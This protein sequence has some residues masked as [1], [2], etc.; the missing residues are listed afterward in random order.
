MLR[1]PHLIVIL[2]ARF[3]RHRV[4]IFDAGF[5]L[6]LLATAA[7]FAFEIDIFATESQVTLAAETLELNELLVLCTLTVCGVLFYTWRR[8]SEHQRENL[9][10]IEA[11]REV[12]S[13]ALHDPLT[14]LPNRRQ[15]DAALKS[16][17]NPFRRRPRRT[18]SS[19]S[20]STASRRSTMSTDTRSA[21]RC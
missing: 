13:L 7:L 10:R 8:A 9:R 14:G 16:A 19:C 12:L 21:T 1:L 20:T 11:E 2:K 4:K 3:M 15:F 6:S 17:L 18:R 5:V